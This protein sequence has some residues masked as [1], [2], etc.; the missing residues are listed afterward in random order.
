MFLIQT[1]SG[2]WYHNRTA[3]PESAS[4]QGNKAIKSLLQCDKCDKTFSNRN[5]LLKHQ[6][7]N[8]TGEEGPLILESYYY[9]YIDRVLVLIVCA[10]VV[11]KC[12]CGSVWTVTALWRASRSYSSTYA[13]VRRVRPALCSAVWSALSTSPQSLSS[14]STSC[15]NICRSCKR[16]HRHRPPVLKRWR[17]DLS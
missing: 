11:Q 4:A 8:H 2:L 16:K 13:A 12:T 1:L 10:C 5:S 3:H 9:C 15:P 14:S 17:P 6:I 7:T